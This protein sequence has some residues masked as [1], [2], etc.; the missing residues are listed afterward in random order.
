MKPRHTCPL[1]TRQS[2]EGEDFQGV[3][4]TGQLFKQNKLVV[5][6]EKSKKRKEDR[7]EEKKQMDILIPGKTKGRIG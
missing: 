6:T 4:L 7:K 5:N 3:V 1:G 2:T